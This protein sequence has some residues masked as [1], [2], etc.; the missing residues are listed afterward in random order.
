MEIPNIWYLARGIKQLSLHLNFNPRRPFCDLLCKL[1]IVVLWSIDYTKAMEINSYPD[2]IINWMKCLNLILL[3]K[4]RLCP[5]LRAAWAG[6]MWFLDSFIDSSHEFWAFIS[7]P[8]RL[9]LFGEKRVLSCDNNHRI[10]LWSLLQRC[11]LFSSIEAVDATH[12]GSVRIG[13]S[14][15]GA[16]APDRALTHAPS[17][18]VELML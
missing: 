7:L 8:F 15:F 11:F 14:D 16:I 6:L 12:S 2:T 13:G 9:W 3:V 17:P 4:T 5:F 10:S 18:F 1:F